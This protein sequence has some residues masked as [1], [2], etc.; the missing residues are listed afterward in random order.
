MLYGSLAMSVIVPI[1]V[2]AISGIAIDLVE[3]QIIMIRP[4]DAVFD[5][6][7]QVV[8]VK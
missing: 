4:I 2:H 5:M 3:K 8:D 1:L 6:L 7:G